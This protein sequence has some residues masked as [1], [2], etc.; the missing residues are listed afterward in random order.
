[1]GSRRE[2]LKIFKDKI[3]NLY[4]NNRIPDKTNLFSNIML[5]AEEARGILHSNLNICGEVGKRVFSVYIVE[6]LV[7]DQFIV[8]IQIPDGKKAK[9]IKVSDKIKYG[10]DKESD[11]SCDFNVWFIDKVSNQVILPTHDYMFSWYIRLKNSIDERVVY[12]MISLLI[13]DRINYPDILSHYYN[14]LKNES[15][16]NELQKFLATLK[17]L[18]LEED[19]N[20]QPPKYMG[21]KYMLAAYALLEMGFSPQEIRRLIRFG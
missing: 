11:V 6:K 5:E 14:M 9:P 4:V 21:S 3:I 7:D 13:R 18:T 16:K 10:L 8:L 12:D 1:L 2:R 20:Y 19:V 15:I 17:W